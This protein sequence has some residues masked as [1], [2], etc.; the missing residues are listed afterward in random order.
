MG[1][2]HL[3]FHEKLAKQY[4]GDVYISCDVFHSPKYGTAHF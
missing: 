1:L 3:L 4:D 2:H